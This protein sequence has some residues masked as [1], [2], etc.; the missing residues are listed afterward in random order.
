MHDF[1]DD[2]LGKVA[3][4]GVYDVTANL[5]RVSVGI[6]HDTAEFAVQSIRHWWVQMG[7]PMPRDLAATEPGAKGQLRGR[8]RAST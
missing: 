4:Y 3:P 1:I 8:P 6:D 7:R 2:E 5:G